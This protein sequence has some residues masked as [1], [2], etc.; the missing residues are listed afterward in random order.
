MKKRRE[1]ITYLSDNSK[2]ILSESRDRLKSNER[3]NIVNSSKS[4]IKDVSTSQKASVNELCFKPVHERLFK[5][6]S[7]FDK[8]RSMLQFKENMKIKRMVKYGS[9]S[10][11]SS[12]KKELIA[13][14]MNI[15]KSTLNINSNAP[16]VKDTAGSIISHIDS[17]NEKSNKSKSRERIEHDA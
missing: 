8:N 9:R 2:R 1:R 12:Q 7:I 17:K 11:S 3:I 6:R 14:L 13:K 10:R 16:S 4:D 5:E 15:S